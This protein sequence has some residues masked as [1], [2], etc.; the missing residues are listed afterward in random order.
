LGLNDIIHRS[1]P[2]QVGSIVDYE[3]IFGGGD[4]LL[5]K[6]TNGEI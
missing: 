2:V 5:V 1:S 4:V 3:E 6:R